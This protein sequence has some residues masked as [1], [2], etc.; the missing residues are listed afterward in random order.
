MCDQMIRHMAA[1]DVIVKATLCHDCTRLRRAARHDAEDWS[2]LVELV[3]L[4]LWA[5]ICL[6][7]VERPA[8]AGLGG[9]AVLKYA[10][11]LVS[12]GLLQVVQAIRV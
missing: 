9:L 7:S 8:L 12:W 5:E 4:R 11:V 1:H 3:T 2:V 6:L 10:V